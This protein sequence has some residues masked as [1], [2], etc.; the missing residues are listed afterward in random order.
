MIVGL[1]AGKARRRTP[2][3]ERFL[4]YVSPDARTGCW[5]W[6]GSLRKGYGRFWMDRGMAAHCAGYVMLCGEIAPGLQLD[7]LCRN[8]ACVNPA[9]LEP[10]TLRENVLRGVGL[11]ADQARRTHCLKAGHPLA[12][13]NLL[14]NK[15]GFRSCKA[16]HRDR[17]RAR[18]G[19][20][21]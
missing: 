20:A 15:R 21:H 16:C 1:S 4:R 2:P 11:T 3:I 9:H 18:R 7:H 14:H 6:T 10:V 17:A 19:Y 5:L 12:P 13:P 8:R